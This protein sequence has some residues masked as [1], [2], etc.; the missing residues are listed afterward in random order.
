MESFELKNGD[1]LL[2]FKQDHNILLPE[3]CFSSSHLC[4]TKFASGITN[5]P[6]FIFKFIDIESFLELNVIKLF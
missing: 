5:I 2:K 6:P 1:I 3:Y 4:A